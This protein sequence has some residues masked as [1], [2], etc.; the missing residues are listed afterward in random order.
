MET[1]YCLQEPATGPSRVHIVKY[2]Y[3]NFVRNCSS[4]YVQVS[5]PRVVQWLLRGFK[6]VFVRPKG[7]NRPSSVVTFQR[8]S[9]CPY[10]YH[11]FRHYAR[12][13]AFGVSLSSMDAP[14]LSF[15]L[16]GEVG[17][18][19]WYMI[20]TL[21]DVEQH[22]DWM[23]EETL[24]QGRRWPGRNSNSALASYQNRGRCSIRCDRYSPP[25]GLSSPACVT[26]AGWQHNQYVA[27]ADCK[28]QRR[29]AFGN[30]SASWP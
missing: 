2:H 9:Y 18:Y 25:P 29:M 24:C 16:V 8:P 17:R 5:R 23:V 27:G 21:G 13:L 1:V 19:E 6:V 14:C 22:W 12:L 20:K 10:L 30:P 28:Q 11:S 7:R 3:H 4:L 15:P 26:E